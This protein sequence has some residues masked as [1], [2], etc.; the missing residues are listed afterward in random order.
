[1]MKFPLEKE[2]MY[3]VSLLPTGEQRSAEVRFA[4]MRLSWFGA[5]V[6]VGAQKNQGW[7]KKG[8][9]KPFIFWH[10]YVS[11]FLNRWNRSTALVVGVPLESEVNEATAGLRWS[12]VNEWKNPDFSRFGLIVGYNYHR[13]IDDYAGTGKQWRFIVG[14]DYKL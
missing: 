4:N 14:V 11:K 7:F 5:G 9:V 2:A 1:M 3:R 12:P 6:G 13:P 8:T 10:L